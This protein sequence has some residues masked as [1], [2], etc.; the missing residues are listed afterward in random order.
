MKK[1]DEPVFEAL[2]L[3][4][5]VGDCISQLDSEAK[6]ANISLSFSGER[7]SVFGS[8]ENLREAVFDLVENSIKYNDEGG[9]IWVRVYTSDAPTISIKDDGKG[10]PYADPIITNVKEIVA[11]HQA[12]LISDNGIGDGSEFKVVF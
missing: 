1:A 3:S 10:T 8:K 9:H 5:L 2:E 7:C 11:L 12:K 4:N 6:K